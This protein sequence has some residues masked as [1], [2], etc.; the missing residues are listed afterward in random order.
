MFSRSSSELRTRAE[1]LQSR[2]DDAATVVEC[3]ASVGGGA[4]PNTRIP[5]VALAFQRGAQAIETRLRLGEPA[6]IGR[7]TEGR[8]LIDMRT[9]QPSEDDVLAAALRAALSS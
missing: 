5:S 8:L 6:V 1:A 9:V 3:D 2:L 4:F 7:I